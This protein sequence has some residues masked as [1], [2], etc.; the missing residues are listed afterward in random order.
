MIS[1]LLVHLDCCRWVIVIFINILDSSHLKLVLKESD[2]LSFQVN[3]SHDNFW[4]EPRTFFIWGRFVKI[5]QNFCLENSF[6]T[7]INNSFKGVFLWCLFLNLIIV[8]IIGIII[9]NNVTII[10]FDKH[11]IDWIFRRIFDIFSIISISLGNIHNN[12][13]VWNFFVDFVNFVP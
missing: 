6:G 10:I 11:F 8:W 3:L 7:F 5:R 12:L 1:V 2:F 9:L 13:A 4:F